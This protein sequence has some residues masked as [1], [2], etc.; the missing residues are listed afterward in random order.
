VREEESAS[1]GVIKLTSNIALDTLDGVA[2]LCGHKDEEVGEGGEGSR[3]VSEV[4]EDDQV[5]LVTRDTQDRG[6]PEV[7][8]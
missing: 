7:T 2:K 4:I 5:I 1:E 3:V 6:G 8:V